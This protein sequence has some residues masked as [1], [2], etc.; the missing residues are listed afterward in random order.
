MEWCS[1]GIALGTTVDVFY[2]TFL[3]I[4]KFKK[5]QDLRLRN[6]ESIEGY[7]ITMIEIAQRD[8]L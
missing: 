7:N 4:Q 8:E 3:F 2:N 6:S 1:C 5:M